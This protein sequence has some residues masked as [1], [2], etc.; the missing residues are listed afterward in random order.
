M[1][2]KINKVFGLARTKTA[3]N[4]YIVFI[5]NSLAG[6]IGMV[7]MIF[8]SRILGPS[9]FGTFSVSFALLS[10]LAKFA[11]LGFNFAMVKN[12][13]QSRARGEKFRIPRIFQTV[14]LVKIVTS[15]LIAV[16]GFFI[17]DFI[18]SHLFHS[19]EAISANHFLMIS[20]FVFVFYDLSRVYFEANK[21]FLESSLMYVS[22]NFFKL[23]T[24]L[25]LFF[26]APLFNNY[27]LVYLFGPLCSALIFFPRAKIKIKFKFYKD[28]F[29]KLI[30]FSSWMGVSVIFAAIGE[31]LNIFMIS[32]RLS[33]FE[34]GIY[35]AA[36]K[37]ILPF[38]IFAGALGT[39][40]ISRT[41]EFLETTHIKS[42]IK[43]VLVIQVLFLFLFLVIYPLTPLVPFVLGQDYLPSVAVLQVLL[44]AS[45]FQL[46]ITP[47][48]A[49]FYPLGKSII[50]AL[51]A[52]I[53]VLFL[54]VFNNLFLLKFQAK[55]AAFSLLIANLTIF[56][57][58][59]CFLYFALKKRER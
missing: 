51:D 43:K 37:F 15:F 16:A 9:K 46:A 30:Q 4:T 36:E 45:F 24:V 14:F 54:F 23:V 58:N 17:A 26:L 10:L 11:D 20:F 53:Q 59:Y 34:T 22:A 42:F 48:N 25:G 12:V 33:S 32:S 47:L 21:R 8:L 56:I 2:K 7:L 19:P 41:S 5:G 57:V 55:G 28:E 35:S 44:I 39:V 38:T 50:F 6:L 49:V 40:L 13:S 29:K 52:F 1:R 3:K 31:N 18:S 27:I